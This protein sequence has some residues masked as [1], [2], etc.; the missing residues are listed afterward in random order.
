MKKILIAT[1]FSENAAHAAKYGHIIATQI[2]AGIVLCNAFIV[3][4]EI[5]QAGTL[6][7]PQMEYD[8]L[9]ESSNSE[10]KKLKDDLKKYAADDVYIPS[11]SCVSGVGAVTGVI[12]EI[13][14]KGDVEMTVMGV[15][16]SGKLGTLLVGNHSRQMIDE[17]H[18]P[19]LLVPSAAPVKPVKKVAFATDLE[20]PEKD[21]E[22]IYELIPLLKKL[23]A[24]LLLTHIYNG[25]DPTYK[26]KQHIQQLLVELSNKANYPNIF[27]RIV[28][29]NK[30]ENGLDWLCDHGNVDI[31]AMVHR[32]HALLDK[33]FLGSYTQK[34]ANHIHVPLLVIPE[35]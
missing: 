11:I 33:I 14:D 31:L 26:F 8:E 27:Y 24:E 13:T 20:H 35:K 7:W 23:N 3:P 22:V 1:D 15:H 28:N 6:V 29:S 2:K 4:A 25:D 16:G 19:L 9:V 30:A 18:T 34:M 12:R 21:L 5:P 17:T 10:L 32:K